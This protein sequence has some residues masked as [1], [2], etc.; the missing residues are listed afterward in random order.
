M[1][2]SITAITYTLDNLFDIA[3]PNI[4][5]TFRIDGNYAVATLAER[6]VLRFPLMDSD[7]NENLLHG[8]LRLSTLRTPWG[9]A[10]PIY[11]FA[12]EDNFYKLQ[13][14]FVTFQCDLITLSFFMLSRYEETCHTERDLHNRFLF[15]N[16]MAALY[17]FID[18][19]IVDEYAMMLRHWVSALF[20]DLKIEKRKG[21]LIATHDIDIISRF[22]S[23]VKNIRTILGGDLLNRRSWSMTKKSF[24]QYNDFCKD[25]NKDPYIVA[26]EMLLR[27]SVNAQTPAIFFFKALTENEND[28]TYSI[29]QPEV[30][31][32]VD[33]IEA[34][35]KEVGLHGSYNSYNDEPTFLREKSR[36][37]EV[38]AHSVNSQRQH[39]LRFDLQTTV[40]VWQSAGIKHDYTLGY[41][42]HEGFRCGTAHPYFLYDVAGDK[43][44]DVME[45]PLIAMDGTFFQ[46]RQI[47]TQLS[48]Q[49]MKDLYEICLLLE[50]DFVIL[51]HNT[52][53]FREYER[54]YQ[55]VFRRFMEEI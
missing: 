47:D 41:A 24:S 33:I 43:P 17:Q 6:I 48:L 5:R 8:K 13:N 42:E 4:P 54:W 7:Q 20:P 16:S 40:D 3:F 45:H 32:M 10:V 50:G 44:T 28:A 34:A 37:E 31:Y 26:I 49:R 23:L 53:V 12:A 2:L 9:H 25:K 1:I 27:L 46:Y 15:S 39:Y 19:P 38:C 30:K 55:E 18:Y 52:T 35:G 29:Y 51:W 22:G 11:Q 36:I 14:Q 21:Q